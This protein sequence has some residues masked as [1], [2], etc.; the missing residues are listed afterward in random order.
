MPSLAYF[1]SFLVC[2][3]LILKILLESNIHAI[4]KKGKVVYI[5]LFYF[6][7]TIIISYLFASAIERFVYVF[8]DI[9]SK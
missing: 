3:P 2:I 8:I 4:F 5:Y 9:I 7:M 1:L 6:L